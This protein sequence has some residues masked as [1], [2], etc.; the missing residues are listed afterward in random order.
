[1]ERK[2]NRFA[3]AA[4]RGF[5]LIELLVVVAIIG[6]LGTIAIK[7]VVE[8]LKKANITAAEATVKSVSEAVTTYY[9]KNK[10]MPI[11]PL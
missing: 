11:Q 2:E 9:I 1:M 10:K 8:N 4:R 5:T 7:N 6:I 3:E